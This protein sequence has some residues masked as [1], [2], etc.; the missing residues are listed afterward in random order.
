M[1]K[2]N[3]TGARGEQIAEQ[4]LLDKGYAI[5]HRNWRTGHKEV[6]LIALDGNQ[7]VFVEIKTRSSFSMGFPEESV[8][9]RKEAHMLAAAE[10]F[11]EKNDQY[12]TPRY[13]VVSVLLRG[14]QVLEVAHLIDA[15]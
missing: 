14:A 11:L 2:N 6:D 13:D 8:D 7:L 3:V 5:L 15:F 10:I 1:G 4:Y 9:A 12:T